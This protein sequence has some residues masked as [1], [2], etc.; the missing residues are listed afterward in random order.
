MP[1][2]LIAVDQ[3]R[4]HTKGAYMN[5]NVAITV[6]GVSKVFSQA[7]EH[8][9]RALDNVS[10]SIAK[11]EVVIRPPVPDSIWALAVT[12]LSS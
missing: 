3:S 11:N 2:R 4:F 5:D 9:V 10:V 12:Y 7:T 1:A 8:E 6:R